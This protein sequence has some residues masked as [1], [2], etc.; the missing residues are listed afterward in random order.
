ML[1]ALKSQEKVADLCSK[2]GVSQAQYYEWRDAFL[3]EGSKIFDGTSDKR[4]I[5]LESQVRRLTSLVGSLTVELKK[6]ET[7][8][9]WLES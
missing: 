3:R 2:H 4:T 7:E 1:E 5:Q 6:T 8:L 9:S